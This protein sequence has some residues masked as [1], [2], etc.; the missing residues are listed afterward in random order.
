MNLGI[1]HLQCADPVRA[2]DCFREG[3]TINPEFSL[4]HYHLGVACQRQGRRDAA[5]A[6]WKQFLER[7]RHT[8]LAEEVLRELDD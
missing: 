5:R 8:E 1:A 7:S 6:A 3:I 4:N 2:E